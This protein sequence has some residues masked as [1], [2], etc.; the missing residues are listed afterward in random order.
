MLL[1][2]L[3]IPRHFDGIPV[4]YSRPQVT[5]I[6]LNNS[7]VLSV[8]VLTTVWLNLSFSTSLSDLKWVSGWVVISSRSYLQGVQFPRL[9]NCRR[10]LA[11]MKQTLNIG[12]RQNSFLS[13]FFFISFSLYIQIP[14][15]HAKPDLMTLS[16]FERT[17]PLNKEGALDYQALITI[18]KS[19][20]V[21][22]PKQMTH[23][24]V[25]LCCCNVPLLPEP[26]VTYSHTMTLYF[27][28]LK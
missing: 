12:V 14:K 1:Q 8:T 20:S 17:E 5:L 26:L 10:L 24:S 21:I 15:A 6:G 11:I 13:Q 23:S 2:F 4:I 18:Q 3:S 16:H 9:C 7:W 25:V 19:K 28:C 27:Q 22:L